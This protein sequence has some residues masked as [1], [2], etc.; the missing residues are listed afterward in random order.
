MRTRQSTATE[1]VVAGRSDTD[2]RCQSDDGESE[3]PTVLLPHRLP[4]LH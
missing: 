4:F 1:I 2:N 3:R